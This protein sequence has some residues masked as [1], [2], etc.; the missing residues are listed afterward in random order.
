MFKKLTISLVLM[1]M[2]AMLMLCSGCGRIWASWSFNDDPCFSNKL[3]PDPPLSHIYMGTRNYF[4]PLFADK[5]PWQYRS[6]G[7][8]KRKS[9][10]KKIKPLVVPVGL[11]LVSLDLSISFA[12]DTVM[13]PFDIIYE[14]D[15]SDTRKKVEAALLKDIEAKGYSRVSNIVE[16]MRNKYDY[17]AWTFSKKMANKYIQGLLKKHNLTK[18]AVNKELKAKYGIKGNHSWDRRYP[19]IIVRREDFDKSGTVDE[20]DLGEFT[21]SWLNSE[22]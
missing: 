4:W 19:K 9:K 22:W 2:I 3:Y 20:F 12:L 16:Q 7:K 13:L 5:S 1:S 8:S 14:F 21:L 6:K 11:L 17:D 10:S 18:V 15:I